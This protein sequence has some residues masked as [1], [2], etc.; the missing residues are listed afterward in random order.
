M[1]YGQR[2]AMVIPI[3][4]SI[5]V[6]APRSSV[7]RDIVPISRLAP[8]RDYAADVVRRVTIPPKSSKQLARKMVKKAAR[9]LRVSLKEDETYSIQRGWNR[10][11]SFNE[12]WIDYSTSYDFVGHRDKAFELF[13][14]LM[15]A[16][17][18]ETYGVR[19][20]AQMRILSSEYDSWVVY[21]WQISQPQP[22]VKTKGFRLFRRR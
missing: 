21:S 11:G 19:V 3:L 20:E 8:L 13:E 10:G 2:L 5:P 7:S 22:E 9:Q 6:S 16:Y 18:M 12:H 1:N 17:V 14:P 4:L 15:E